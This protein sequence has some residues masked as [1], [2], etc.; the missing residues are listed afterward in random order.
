MVDDTLTSFFRKQF[1]LLQYFSL[2]FY[3]NSWQRLALG[4]FCLFF[5]G[6]FGYSMSGN[7]ISERNALF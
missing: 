7:I 4:F 5:S 3:L 6:L 1:I 2:S